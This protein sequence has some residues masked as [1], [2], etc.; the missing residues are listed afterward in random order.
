M[1]CLRMRQTR[2]VVATHNIDR[3]SNVMCWECNTARHYAAICP[4]KRPTAPRHVARRQHTHIG[5]S[6]LAQKSVTII[7]QGE[8]RMCCDA[9]G[10]MLVQ[11]PPLDTQIAFNMCR[12]M[13]CC[14]LGGMQA[15]DLERMLP[16]TRPTSRNAHAQR[17]RNMHRRLVAQTNSTRGKTQLA[18]PTPPSHMADKRPTK[19]GG[20]QQYPHGLN[21]L[22]LSG[23]IRDI[24]SVGS[25]CC[26]ACGPLRIQ[27]RIPF[28]KSCTGPRCTMCSKH[29]A[30]NQRIATRH[31]KTS[32]PITG[33]W[34]K[35]QPWKNGVLTLWGVPGLAC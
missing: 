20:L 22:V 33:R 15:H 11:R 16:M 26:V 2:K 30:G 8:H 4:H 18:T 28:P 3:V 5:A 32:A 27:R 31:Q 17:T 7:A 14:L 35:R 21:R 1:L 12:G 9:S 13:C 29:D 6:I 24:G 10:L 23:A 25:Q 19:A 34:R